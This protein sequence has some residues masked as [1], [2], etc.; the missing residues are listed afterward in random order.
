MPKDESS[1]KIAKSS[2]T[3][4]NNKRNNRKPQTVVRLM[5]ATEAE[6]VFLKKVKKVV[7]RKRQDVLI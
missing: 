7:D 6:K 5:G 1:D 3:T 2:K 4:G